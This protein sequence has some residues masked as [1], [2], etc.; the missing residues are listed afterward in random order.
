[1]RTSPFKMLRF[2]A[3]PLAMAGATACGD[4]T[5]TGATLTVALTDAAD[6]LLQSAVVEIGE[7]QIIPASGSPVTLS[8]DGGTHDLLALQGG[9]TADL[10][11]LDIDPGTY[12][13]LRI[14][15]S[16][17]TVT[18]KPGLT[19]NDGTDTK[20]LVVPS[21]AQSGIKINLDAADGDAESEGID[22]VAGETILVVDFD[23]SQNFVVQG[24][25]DTA[26]GINGI[27]FTPLL[28]ATVRNVAGSIAGAVTT[29]ADG[30]AVEG[31]TVRAVQT[32]SGLMEELQTAEATAVTDAAGSYRIMFLAPGSYEVTVDSLTTEPAS[33]SVTV[34][35]GE[36]VTGVDFTSG[37]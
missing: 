28:R 25:A 7:I 10:A 13:Q 2:L 9:V 23:V 20:D 12:L 8:T 26:A 35:E 19:F 32:Q 37:G 3:V 24:N 5:G 1:M 33:R 27:L 30:S 15:V 11:T 21:G 14:V 18:L 22:I 34:G 36:D 4:S 6:T 17:A 29:A 31:A 16:A